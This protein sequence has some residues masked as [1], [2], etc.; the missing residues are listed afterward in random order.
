[1]CDSPRVD[2]TDATGTI[3]VGE[4]GETDG[5]GSQSQGFVRVLFRHGGLGNAIGSYIGAFHLV[6]AWIL[7]TDYLL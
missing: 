5:N 1:M 3:V 2:E 6:L 7:C 4:G